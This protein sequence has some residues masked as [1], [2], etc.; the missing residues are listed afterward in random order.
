MK[1]KF[2]ILTDV[3]LYESDAIFWPHSFL[4]KV[5][6]RII[7]EAFLDFGDDYEMANFVSCFMFEVTEIL[8]SVEYVIL[9]MEKSNDRPY[10]TNG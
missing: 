3:D 5:G 6:D 2:S 4:P 7:I 1:I 9:G 8:W 10:K